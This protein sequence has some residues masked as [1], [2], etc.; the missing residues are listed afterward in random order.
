MFSYC[1]FSAYK[2]RQCEKRTAKQLFYTS[3]FWQTN[4]C[5]FPT[6]KVPDRRNTDFNLTSQSTCVVFV[7]RIR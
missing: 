4:K 1:L 2:K 3:S 7:D 6:Y 5:L